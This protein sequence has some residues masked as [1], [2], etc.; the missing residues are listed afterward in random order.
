MDINGQF[1]KGKDDMWYLII[2]DD[3][4]V[5]RKLADV[6]RTIRDKITEKTLD[7]IEYDED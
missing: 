5:F 3:D 4:D 2:S 6:F 7:T 1:K